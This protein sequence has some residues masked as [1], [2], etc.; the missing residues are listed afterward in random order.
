MQQTL[1]TCTRLQTNRLDARH[2]HNWC[3]D[4]IWAYKP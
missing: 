1:H 4:L 2:A 3:L